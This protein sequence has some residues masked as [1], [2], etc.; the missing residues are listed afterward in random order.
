VRIIAETAHLST[1]AASD[2]PN[3]RGVTTV[4]GKQWHAMSVLRARHRFGLW[5][6]WRVANSGVEKFP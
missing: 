3:R 2:T 6:A 5:P 4:S 1:R